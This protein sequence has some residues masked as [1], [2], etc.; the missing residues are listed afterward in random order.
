MSWEL[1]Q[2]IVLLLAAV[3]LFATGRVRMDVTALLLVVVFVLSGLLSLPEALVGFSD[4]NVILIAALFVVGE[5]WCV[6]GW[7]IR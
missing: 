1:L 7:P 2:V 3:V 6:P 4:P 5:G